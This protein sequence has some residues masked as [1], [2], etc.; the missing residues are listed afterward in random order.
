MTLQVV[1]LGSD[2]VVIASDTCVERIK[3]GRNSRITDS[4]TALGDRTITASLSMLL[5]EV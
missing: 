2:G 5:G 3:P 1:L 4:W